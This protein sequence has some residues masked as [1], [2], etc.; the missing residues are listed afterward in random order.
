MS[1]TR[2]LALTLAFVGSLGGSPATAQPRLAIDLIA[3][4]GAPMASSGYAV[5]GSAGQTATGGASSPSFATR[6]GFWLDLGSP[7]TSVGD[8]H[9]RPRVLSLVQNHPNPFNPST[10]ITFALPARSRVRLAVYDLAGRLVAELIDEVRTPGVYEQSFAPTE[11]ASGVYLYRLE[12]DG[13]ARQRKLI[14]L[15]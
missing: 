7:A 5:R 12:A 10:T 13:V 8:D 14:L 15:K 3:G 2:L 9:D 6:A 4:G 11:L 1:T